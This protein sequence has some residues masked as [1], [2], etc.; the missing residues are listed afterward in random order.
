[1]S[2]TSWPKELR[3]RITDAPD[4]VRRIGSNE[5][6]AV[7]ASNAEPSE[8]VD[9]LR[10]RSSELDELKVLLWPGG[11][12]TPLA[13]PELAPHLT[14]QLWVPNRHTRRALASGQAVYIPGHVHRSLCKLAAG[15]PPLAGAL[16][17]LT[18]P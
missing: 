12:P 11:F 6:I 2:S 3:E 16:V 7:G 13:D 14:L 5:L 1:M 9:A 18:P 4:A 8:L 15:E 17:V 10:A